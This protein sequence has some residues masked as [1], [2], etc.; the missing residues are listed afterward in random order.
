MLP[1]VAWLQLAGCSGTTTAESPS[2][3]PAQPAA[4]GKAVARVGD[5]V[6]TDKDFAEAAARTAPAGPTLSKEERR[7]VLDELVTEEVLFQEAVA[8]GLYRDPKVRKILVNIL[9][10]E[11]VYA[12]VRSAEVP[13][14][15]LEAYYNAHPDEFTIPEKVQIKR[16]YIR[17]GGDSDRTEA[18]AITLGK[19]LVSRIKKDPTV[20]KDLA[21]QYSDDPNKRR[22]GD[23]GYVGR[24]GVPG[25]PPEVIER[26]FGA[27]LNQVTEPFVAG[28]GVNIVIVPS[29]REA[30][31]RSFEQMQSSVLRRLKNEKFQDL[32][33]QYID[34]A[35]SKYPVSVD[36]AA[37]DAVTLDPHA[38]PPTDPGS[39]MPGVGPRPE[40]AAPSGEPELQDE[41]PE[42]SE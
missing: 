9:L 12:S 15:E 41:E 21:E 2:A 42:G 36:E 8:R 28:E 37:L 29:K 3:G 34:R 18:D 40:R 14:E 7:K 6:I 24:E 1:W 5:A 31:E 35:K 33:K 30:I 13:R 39:M 38:A 19:D 22:G 16:I 10:R 25:V 20:F 32:T 11:E 17:F 4:D 23:L 26:A 27:P